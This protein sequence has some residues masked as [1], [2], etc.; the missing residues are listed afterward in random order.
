MSH[1]PGQTRLR[2][3]I[4]VDTFVHSSFGTVVRPLFQGLLTAPS[5]QPFPSLACGWALATDRHTITT[6]VWLPGATTIK[7]FARVSVFLG[8]P[9]S[10]RRWQLWGAVSR[11]AVPCVPAGEV[12]RVI[13]DDTTKKNAGTPSAGLAWYRHGAGSA[14]H[15]YRTLRGVTCVLGLMRLPLK[16]WPSHRLSVP[17]GLALSLQPAHA[18][19]LNVPY[20]SRSPLARDRLECVA[21]Q[22]PGRPIRSLADGGYATQDSMRQWPKGTHVVGR[23]PISAQLSPLPPTPPPKR[24][25][26]LRKTGDLLGSPKTLV[27]TAKGCAPHPSEAGAERQ[28]W[29]GLWHAVVPGRLVRVVVRR[30]AGKPAPPQPK[31]KKPLPAIEAYLCYHEDG[32]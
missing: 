11:L 5:W 25:G 21:P 17:V 7:H 27:Q 10:H 3:A 13:F 30:R 18:T 15:E 9:L 28:A 4:A 20:R 32:L 23:W 2:Q 31:Q 19:A 1:R 24:R 12:M 8:G 6:S 26:A 22:A 14:R 16:R 29:E